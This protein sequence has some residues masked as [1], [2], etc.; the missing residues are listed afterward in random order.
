MGAAVK[1][2]VIALAASGAAAV[3]AQSGDLL[4]PKSSKDVHAAVVL[5]ETTICWNRDAFDVSLGSSPSASQVK[6]VRT[7]VEWATATT[8]TEFEPSKPMPPYTRFIFHETPQSHKVSWAM[9]VAFFASE[10]LAK[11]AGAKIA[12]WYADALHR[13]LKGLS[14]GMYSVS[15]GDLSLLVLV[16]DKA[17]RVSCEHS[18][19]Q[20][21]AVQ[22]GLALP[23]GK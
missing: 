11:E 21:I 10:A 7:N 14:S 16:D 13:D 18:P 9:G 22:E 15:E 17:V 2:V 8:V 4:K 5:P 19:T 12:Q 23:R 1:I 20:N 6:V 3:S